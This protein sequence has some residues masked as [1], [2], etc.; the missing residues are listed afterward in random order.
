MSRIYSSPDDPC[1]PLIDSESVSEFFNQRANKISS[2]GPVQAVIYQ[3]K[4]PELAKK[5][6]EAEKD[7]LLP[8]LGL[9]GSERVLDVGCGTGRWASD[10]LPNCSWYHGFDACDGLVTYA[11]R[12][13]LS[14]KCKFSTASA[15]AFSLSSLGESE[16]FN[17]VLCAGVLI[18]LNDDE[19]V[20]ALRCIFNVLAPAGRVL[21]REP[22]GLSRR[23]TISNHY[24][25][26][27]SQDYSA[28]YRTKTELLDMV[29]LAAGNLR[30]TLKDSGAVYDSPALNNRADTRQHWMLLEQSE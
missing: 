18:Y 29:K 25:D 22:M 4:N 9:D 23:L 15:D 8:L 27:L 2:I 10:I 21:L 6:N 14:S 20:S 1:N 19:V 13:N 24:S 12:T 5:R 3:D 7:K 26:E 17:R 30:I 11:R 16:G 28:I